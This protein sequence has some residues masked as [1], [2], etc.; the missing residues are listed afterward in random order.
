MV[1]WET[2]STD[3]NAD[4]PIAIIGGGRAG[5]AALQRFE[6]GDADL[7]SDLRRNPKLSIFAAST[8]FSQKRAKDLSQS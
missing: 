1:R 5:G 8:E 3:L 7:L 4:T 2:A 6:L